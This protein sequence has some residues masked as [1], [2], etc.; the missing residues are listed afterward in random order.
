M[1][2]IAG[3]HA[4]EVRAIRD[5]T[6]HWPGTESVNH[7]KFVGMFET[8]PGEVRMPT[9]LQKLGGSRSDPPISL[10]S[11]NGAMPHATATAPPPVLPPQVFV[12]S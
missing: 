9:A 1:L 12:T 6:S 7:P 3:E 10:P 4:Q 5:V 11:A 8:L 2:V